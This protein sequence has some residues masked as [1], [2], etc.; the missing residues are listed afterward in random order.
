MKNA[1]ILISTAVLFLSCFS[2]QKT[3]DLQS[4][5]TAEEIIK[6]IRQGKIISIKN[7][8]ILGDLDFTTIPKKHPVAEYAFKIEVKTPI[9]FDNCIFNG[10]ILGF[11]KDSVNNY[12]CSFESDVIF[13]N[14]RIKGVVEHSYNRF[15]SFFT[16]SNNLIED[17]FIASN[18]LFYDEV[19][20]NQSTFEKDLFLTYTIYQ[21]QSNMMDIRVSGK[22]YLQGSDFQHQSLWSNSIF[23]EY[24]DISKVTAQHSLFLD[25]CHFKDQLNISGSRFWGYMNMSASKFD[26]VLT[27]RTSTFWEAPVLSDIKAVDLNYEKNQLLLDENLEFKSMNK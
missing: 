10:N 20:L 11:R 15:K 2:S 27:I 8:T 16:F 7:T 5:I 6:Q 14:C 23:D 3:Q 21:Q 17:D 13:S 19:K 1:L 24:V 9:Y 25:H 12:I 4:T 22:T 18:A 26:N